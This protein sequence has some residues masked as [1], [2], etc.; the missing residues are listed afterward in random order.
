MFLSFFIS[1]RNIHVCRD[2]YLVSKT[3]QA[4]FISKFF[5]NRWLL[6]GM[7]P[8][9]TKKVYLD[10]TKRVLIFLDE[11]EFHTIALLK[12][13]LSHDEF[14]HE[15]HFVEKESGKTRKMV[16]R[17]WPSTTF[18][19]VRSKYTLE[20]TSRWFTASPEIGAEKIIDVID[21]KARMDAHPEYFVEDF[22]FKVWQQ[23]FQTLHDKGPLKVQIPYA[24]TMGKYVRREAPEDMRTYDMLSGLIK[25]STVLH[26]S[27]R[28]IR[29]VLECDTGRL[30]NSGKYISTN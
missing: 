22:E 23:V 20:F 21:V 9:E 2:V 3:M 13:L 15:Y 28:R 25:A 8:P 19:A 6:A 1:I 5:P 30:F 11:P 26:V 4:T 29:G 10:L 16:L 18:C 17:G 27:T 7:S 14:E 12:P 24:E